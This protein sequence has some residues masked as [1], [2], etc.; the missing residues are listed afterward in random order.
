MKTK[1]IIMACFALCGLWAC[2]ERVPDLY[3]A[4]DGIYFNNRTANNVLLDST[5]VTFVYELDET[6]VLDVPVV[7]QSALAVSANRTPTRS[8]RNPP[9]ACPSPSR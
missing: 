2:D 8:M 4:P 9:Q 5:T 1:H 6:E 7:V 3:S